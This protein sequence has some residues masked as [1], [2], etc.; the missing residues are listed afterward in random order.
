M[1]S[2]C[3]WFFQWIAILI[4]ETTN[5]RSQYQTTNQGSYS[6]GHVNTTR[7]SK[8]NSSRTKEGLSGKLGEDSIHAPKRMCHDRIH[9]TNKEGRVQQIPVV[10]ATKVSTLSKRR[11]RSLFVAA[12]LAQCT[13]A[14]ICVRSAMVPAT[15]D[16]TAH[17]KANWKNQSSKGTPLVVFT[18]NSALTDNTDWIRY[19]RQ[20]W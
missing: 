20:R 6:A 2:K 17:A 9:K 14:F 15:I 11:S 8:I 18:K 4:M 19:M 1:R 12:P 13:H 16:D 10:N 3:G 7:T 5:T